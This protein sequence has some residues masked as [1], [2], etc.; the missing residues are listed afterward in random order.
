MSHRAETGQEKQGPARTEADSKLSDCEIPSTDTRRFETFI[1]PPTPQ[2]GEANQAPPTP[3]VG[4]DAN[5]ARA[6][7]SI[8]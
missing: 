5:R 4:P 8:A 6:P 2:Q 3:S 7:E 1:F